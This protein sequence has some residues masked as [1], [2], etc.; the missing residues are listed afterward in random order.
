MNIDQFVANG[1]NKLFGT[2]VNLA[3]EK[4]GPTACKVNWFLLQFGE[5]LSSWLM[6]TLSAERVFALFFPLRHRAVNP[7]K[8]TRWLLLGGTG[9]AIL[10]AAPSCCFANNVTLFGY[11]TVHCIPDLSGN[12]WL[13]MVSFVFFSI[14]NIYF[15]PEAVYATCTLLLVFK[16]T[17]LSRS[18]RRLAH[19]STLIGSSGLV[20]RPER[21]ERSAALTIV[22][23]LIADIT[24]YTPITIFFSSY[25][26]IQVGYPNS[27][28]FQAFL[29]TLTYVFYNIT[30][31]K[32]VSNFYIY[33]CRVRDFRRILLCYC[34]K[35]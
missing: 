16:L 23:L 5:A 3:W 13:I 8:F 22:F 15:F 14:L 12:S 19:N 6:A 18:S 34:Y 11:K 20:N 24:V 1:F 10:M 25:F 27:L 7:T 21:K 32:R 4:S 26:V 30:L 2:S 31:L 29:L 33:M 9:A 17:S 28:P 35:S